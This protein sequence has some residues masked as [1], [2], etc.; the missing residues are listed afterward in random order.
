M[1]RACEFYSPEALRQ[2]W[3]FLT[4]NPDFADAIASSGGPVTA[5]MEQRP[6]VA[7]RTTAGLANG[8]N[9][10]LEWKDPTLQ[11]LPP[12][13]HFSED[14][15]DQIKAIYADV[16]NLP[17][18]SYRDQENEETEILYERPESL[19]SDMSASG[20]CNSGE[21]IEGMA[22]EFSDFSDGEEWESES[23]NSDSMEDMAVSLFGTADLDEILADLSRPEADVVFFQPA[24]PAEAHVACNS[25]RK[26]VDQNHDTVPSDGESEQTCQAKC[27]ALKDSSKLLVQNSFVAEQDL[28][29]I[30]EY[31]ATARVNS[32]LV[33][34]C[35]KVGC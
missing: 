26:P 9:S 30:W 17:S 15:R 29:A 28:T 20:K 18:S 1:E 8:R 5:A 35:L 4:G 34:Q 22:N 12:L 7:S 16:H 11:E 24:V 10:L 13:S 27:R 32:C 2:R 6:G 31:R 3:S 23:E 33:A 21:E 14:V 25:T 19:A